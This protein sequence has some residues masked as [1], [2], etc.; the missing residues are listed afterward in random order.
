[1]ATRCVWPEIKMPSFSLDGGFC[2]GGIRRQWPLPASA[3]IPSKKAT[4]ETDEAAAFAHSISCAYAR[5][6][7]ASS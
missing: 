5:S 2:G 6:D 1:M 3:Q 4:Y 7:Y